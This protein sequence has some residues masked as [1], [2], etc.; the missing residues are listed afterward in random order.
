MH[1]DMKAM[2]PSFLCVVVIN[3]KD[4]FSHLLHVCFF[5]FGF[6]MC[7]FVLQSVV[8]AF[9]CVFPCCNATMCVFD[10]YYSLCF[11]SCF[12]LSFRLMQEQKV[13]F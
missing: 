8:I 13:S 9:I 2:Q 11:W 5:Q 6:W 4:A 1:V 10:I 7:F 12:L 3:M